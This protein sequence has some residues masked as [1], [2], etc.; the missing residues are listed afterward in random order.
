[1]MFEHLIIND[2][3][4]YIKGKNKTE[5]HVPMDPKLFMDIYNFV[6]KDDMNY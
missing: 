1:M 4:V 2:F 5:R 3:V 6:L